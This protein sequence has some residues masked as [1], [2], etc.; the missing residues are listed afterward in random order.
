MIIQEAIRKYCEQCPNGG[1]FYVP[2]DDEG[3]WNVNIN[4][5]NDRN[6]ED[7]TQFDIRPARFCHITGKCADLE[8]LWKT[9]CKENQ[10]RLN[11]VISIEIVGGW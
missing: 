9:F 1:G 6:I 3:Y 5:I 10:F 8:E 2:T 4:F 7:Q 11:S